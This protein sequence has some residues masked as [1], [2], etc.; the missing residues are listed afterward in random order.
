MNRRTTAWILGGAVSLAWAC[1]SS[2]PP[3]P[4]GSVIGFAVDESGNV[5]PGVSVTIQNDKG[6]MV[7]TVIT[8]E[9]GSYAFPTIAPG[10]YQ[11]LTYFKGF[12]ARQPIDVTVQSGKEARLQPLVLVAP[13]EKRP[14]ATPR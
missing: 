7:E 4:T 11:V 14:A 8:A 10:Q 13:G 9:D 3:P 2:A 1:A 5:L 12:Q 6:K